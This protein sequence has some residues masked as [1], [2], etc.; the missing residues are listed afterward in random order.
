MLGKR[1]KPMT[2]DRA[3]VIA[4]TALGELAAVPELAGRF[5]T[6]TGLTPGAVRDAAARTD[7]QAAVLEYVLAD[8][9]LLLSLCAQHGW[10]PE[11]VVS[12]SAM[13]SGGEF[14]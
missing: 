9:S 1:P 11:E 10:Q 4:V 12:A 5:L 6:L 7:F 13:L 2:P 14:G 3:A 8:E